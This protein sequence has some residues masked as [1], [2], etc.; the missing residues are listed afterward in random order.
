MFIAFFVLFIL[1]LPYAYLSW[2]KPLEFEKYIWGQ[3]RKA[4]K[5]IF[6]RIYQPWIKVLA[7][8]PII[9]LVLA[10][11]VTLFLFLLSLLGMF[12]AIHGPIVG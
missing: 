11:L 3:R 5:N 1:N 4:R 6:S 2:I 8:L 10:K 12:I 9:D 7:R